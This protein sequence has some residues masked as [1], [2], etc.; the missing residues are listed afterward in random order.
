MTRILRRGVAALIFAL[1]LFALAFG[2]PE[3]RAAEPGHSLADADRIV[4]EGDAAMESLQF[5]DAL[6]KF[7]EALEIYQR[8][9]HK[10]GIADT[11]F[12]MGRINARTENYP[13]ALRLFEQARK[14][15]EEIGDKKAVVMDMTRIAITYSYQG[16]YHDAIALSEKA[17]AM[18]RDVQDREA[19]IL[20]LD[21]LANSYFDT[22]SNEK[23]LET[24]HQAL[25]LATEVDDKKNMGMVVGNIGQVYWKQGDF[26][27]AIANLEKAKE[28]SEGLG[29]TEVLASTICNLGLVYLDQGELIE[30]KEK[31]EKSMELFQTLGIRDQVAVMHFNIAAVNSYLGNFQQVCDSLQKTIEIAED[32]GDQ[33]LLATARGNLAS[34]YVELGNYEMAG[35]LLKKAMKTSREIGAKSTEALNW[36]NLGDLYRAQGKSKD[37]LAA[38][39][40]T[41]RIAQEIKERLLVADCL[42]RIAGSYSK[43]GI[44]AQELNALHRALSIEEAV[45]N[46]AGIGA[47]NMR[48]GNALYK[49]KRIT[50]ADAALTKSIDILRDI[51]WLD[52]LWP[53]LYRK[54]LIYRDSGNIPES[55]RSLKEAVDIIERMRGQVEFAEQKSAFFEERI[56]IYEDLIQLFVKQ[57]DIAGAFE[58]VE[59]AKARSFLDS[60]SEAHID[61]KTDLTPEQFNLKRQ[62]EVQMMNLNQAIREQYKSETPDL[63]EVRRS[64]QRLAKLDEQ[65][66]SLMSDIRRQNPRFSQFQNPQPIQLQRAEQLIDSD[67]AIAEYFVGKKASLLFVVTSTTAQVFRLP[68]E[69]VLTEQVRTLL[70]AIQKPE[71]VYEASEQAYTRYVDAAASLYN[72]IFKPGEGLFQQKKKIIISPDGALSDIPFECLVTGRV[73]NVIDFSQLNYLSRHYDFQYIPSTSVLEALRLNENRENETVRKS[74]IAFAAPMGN[75]GLTRQ[76][77]SDSTFQQWSASLSDLPYSKVEAEQIARL[78]PQKEVTLMVGTDASETAVKSL[79]LSQYRMIHFASHGLIDEQKPQFSALLL[80]PGTGKLE[81]GFLTMREVFDLKLNADLVVLSACK[82]GLGRQIRGEGIDSLS[83]AFFTAGASNVIMSFWN[84][85]DLSTAQFMTDF[86]GAMLKNGSDKAAALRQARLKM[87]D[88]KQFNHPYYWAPFILMGRN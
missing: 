10:P 54:G 12:K 47:I 86:Y 51:G 24:F 41:L 87:I 27:E 88:G 74:L 34:V 5:E 52:Y 65:Y 31:F 1:I 64:K 66:L 77:V 82:T 35:E 73:S 33:N 71:P 46:R 67:T 40:N 63:A 4:K 8:E 60:L 13:E 14:I 61:P 28:I 26:P 6:K 15:H 75:G 11:L 70:A 80:Y 68:P 36:M 30:A 3:V 49:A 59:R 21:N 62:L 23:A 53:A 29:D 9:N 19:S 42:E 37:A 58:F 38:Y 32:V 81:D 85:F 56:D 22:G 83:R 50:E 43:M 57:N 17:L 48:I 76:G 16:N 25:A 2:A 20:L 45:G 69:R 18:N 44:P 55:V 39:Q 79:N 7:H 84:V 72:G 78:F